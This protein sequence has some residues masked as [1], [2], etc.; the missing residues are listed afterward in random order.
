MSPE[1]AVNCADRTDAHAGPR[2]IAIL[3]AGMI[4]SVHRRAALLAGAEIAGVLASS[5]DRSRHVAE[6]WRVPT[7]YATIDDVLADDRVDAVHICTPNTTHASYAEAALRA[8]KHV[9]C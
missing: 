9:V 3:G 5:P 2:R 6:R 1:P 4:A 8:G 7:A